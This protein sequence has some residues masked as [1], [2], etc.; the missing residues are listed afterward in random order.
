MKFGYGFSIFAFVLI[1]LQCHVVAPESVNCPHFRVEG[2]KYQLIYI[3]VNAS[4]Y[5]EFD[6]ERDFKIIDDLKNKSCPD[7]CAAYVC[8][9][10][11]KI[12]THGYGCPSDFYVA[13][14]EYSNEINE[15]KEKK[16]KDLDY[17]SKD[18]KIIYSRGCANELDGQNCIT[19]KFINFIKELIQS[20]ATTTPTNSEKQPNGNSDSGKGSDPTSDSNNVNDAMKFIGFII[21]GSIFAFWNL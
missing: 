17:R 14:K 3:F 18:R 6:G 8:S 21:F 4:K 11:E 16:A 12:R 2:T 1:F 10:T 13:C 19:N 7:A 9:K 5:L 15:I 20:P